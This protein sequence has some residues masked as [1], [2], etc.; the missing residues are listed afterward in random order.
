[1]TDKPPK[2]PSKEQL[3]KIALDLPRLM[4]EQEKDEE[5]KRCQRGKYAPP[6]GKCRACG[7]PVVAEVCFAHSGRLGG[8]PPHSYI[9]HWACQDCG[10]MYRKCPPPETP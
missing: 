2:L 1:M 10:L 5:D 3:A 7:G 8:P 6:I 4:A 9:P